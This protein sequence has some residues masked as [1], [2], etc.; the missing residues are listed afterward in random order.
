MEAVYDL[1]NIRLE[2]LGDQPTLFATFQL[3]A[4]LVTGHCSELRARSPPRGVQLT[5]GTAA[6]A[7]VTGNPNPDPNLSLSPSPNPKVRFRDR[8]RVRVGDRVVFR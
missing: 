1:D 8:F 2:D 5:L 6:A 3:E 4:L 7:H